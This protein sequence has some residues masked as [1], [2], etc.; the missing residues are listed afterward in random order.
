MHLSFGPLQSLLSLAFRLLPL[1]I[2]L[3]TYNICRRVSVQDLCWTLVQRLRQ[4]IG[5][6]VRVGMLAEKLV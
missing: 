3:P 6:N 5:E 2:H 1:E 4:L